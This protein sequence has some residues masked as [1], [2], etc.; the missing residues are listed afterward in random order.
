MIGVHA[1]QGRGQI[2]GG[3]QRG[4]VLFQDNAGRHVI[5]LQIHHIGALGFHQQVFGLEFIHHPAHLV[6]IKALAGIGIE[7][8]AQKV[9]HLGH[10]VQGDALE[11]FEG[12]QGLLVAVLDLLKPG[13]AQIQ[14]ALVLFALLVK[15]HIQLNQRVHSALFHLFPASPELVGGQHLA[16]LGSP[17][18]QMVDAHAPIAA[19]TI[20]LI[21]GV[22]DHG[23]GQMSNM[24][25]L[26]NVDGGVIDADGLAL[27]AVIAAIALALF[28]GAAEHL[29]GIH[30]P[31]NIKIQIT[32]HRLHLGQEG[33]A[34]RLLQRFGDHGRG[35]AQGL[36]QP[37][38]GKGIVA[39]GGIRG[40]LDGRGHIP[41]AQTGF[42]IHLLK[43]RDD[44]LSDAHA[45]IHSFHL[46]TLFHWIS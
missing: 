32:L 16:E 34:H 46:N 3:V 6:V 31:V 44:V 22:S 28:L 27:A 36:G 1:V 14:Q 5:F 25:A 38:T 40:N 24:E 41:G 13:A 35:F 21:Q 2:P 43:G 42:P 7:F 26:G 39:H 4:A 23:G 12:L 37:K 19:K 45:K 15:L 18:P 11:P 20:Q 30:R 10:V 29:A 33:R 17:V 8:H 9:I